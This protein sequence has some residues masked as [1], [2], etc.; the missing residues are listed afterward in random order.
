MALL[1]RPCRLVMGGLLVLLPTLSQS[2]SAMPEDEIKAA[3]LFNFAKFI[4]WPPIPGNDGPLVLCVLGR[5]AF[6]ATLEHT[7]Q[8]KRVNG[9]PLVVKHLAGPQESKGCQVVFFCGNDKN[10]LK[11]LLDSLPSTSIL[12]VG[13]ADQF[14]Q[15]GGM[16]NFVKDA[17][18]LR[19][20]INVDAASRAGIRISSRLLQLARIVRDDSAAR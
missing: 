12:T 7:V 20:D 6:A 4:E 10:R 19:F 11:Q 16:I 2:E 15:R 9:R 8:N 5:D 1:I 3:F 14:A 17:N 13:E 18:R